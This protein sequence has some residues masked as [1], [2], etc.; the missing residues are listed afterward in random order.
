MNESVSK[1][2]TN[3]RFPLIFMVVTWHCYFCNIPMVD[4]PML[5]L[6]SVG[7]GQLIVRVSVPLFF[8]ISGYLFFVG[9][10][11]QFT[12]V[13][14]KQKLKKRAQTLLLPYILWTLIWICL[15]LVFYKIKPAPEGIKTVYDYSLIDFLFAFINADVIYAG[16]D[17]ILALITGEGLP[18]VGPFW[19]L[20]DLMVLRLFSPFIFY[21]CKVIPSKLAFLVLLT[22]PVLCQGGYLSSAFYFMIGAYLSINKV[23]VLYIIRSSVFL[24]IYAVV[25]MLGIVYFDDLECSLCHRYLIL[26]G[27][28]VF[29][30]VSYRFSIR[31]RTVSKIFVE[32]TF[33]IYA[34]HGLLTKFLVPK[35]QEMA[36]WND[37]T[38]TL[39]YL[40]TPYGVTFVCL[41]LYSA[42]CKVM[43]KTI[44]VL[45][46]NR[47]GTYYN[48]L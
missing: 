13:C 31:G 41:C 1:I 14:Y 2:I 7:I 48:K 29:V 6:F 34:F 20:R 16:K 23:D 21:F 24:Y 35:I 30:G 9:C 46:G 12:V 38:L 18:L 8:V 28:I 40:I 45:C 27:I 25:V 15:Y 43:P 5:H 33:F 10:E 11:E 32:A 37:I 3:L 42:L 44:A 22:S 47:V 17:P 26:L 39:L 4:F 36:P 19:F